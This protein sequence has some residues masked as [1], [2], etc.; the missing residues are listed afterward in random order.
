MH[1]RAVFWLDRQ[2]WDT[3]ELVLEVFSVSS[4]ERLATSK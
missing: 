2:H 4:Q 3:L 1:M